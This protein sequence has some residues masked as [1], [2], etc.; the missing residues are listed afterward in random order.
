MLDNALVICSGSIYQI[1]IFDFYLEGRGQGVEVQKGGRNPHRGNPQK[2]R[3]APAL[4]RT[5]NLPR[6]RTSGPRRQKLSKDFVK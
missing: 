5:L 1:L 6:N 3:R 2:R 4:S